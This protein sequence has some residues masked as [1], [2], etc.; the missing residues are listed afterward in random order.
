MPWL[1]LS[2]AFQA[3]YFSYYLMM[4]TIPIVLWLARTPARR[5]EVILRIAVGYLGCYLIYAFFPVVG[6]REL[7]PNYSG[8]IS[9]GLFYQINAAIRAGGDSLGTAFPSSHTVG[10]LT[11]AWVAWRLAPGR[12]AWAWTAAAGAIALATVYTQNHFPVDTVAG[13]VVG[14]ALQAFV[15][16][17]VAAERVRSETTEP[18]R[19]TISPNLPEA[20]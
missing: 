14:V 4:A 10:A 15:V 5:R 19:F 20:A 6:P 16:P 13:I 7:L 17:A 9:H 3:S 12:I 1:P 2:E 18:D 8:E 11:F